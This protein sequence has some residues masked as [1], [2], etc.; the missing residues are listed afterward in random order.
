MNNAIVITITNTFT[1][2]RDTLAHPPS[3]GNKEI[4]GEAIDRQ[5]TILKPYGK[6]IHTHLYYDRMSTVGSISIQLYIVIRANFVARFKKILWIFHPHNYEHQLVI[7][8][9]IQMI[10]HKQCEQYN[11]Y[12][13]G[14]SYKWHIRQ[15]LLLFYRSSFWKIL[16]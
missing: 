10:L 5:F 15:K 13:P 3:I 14:D 16:S 1:L 8:R 11:G 12:I 4:E 7:L 6:Q 2:I 9:Y